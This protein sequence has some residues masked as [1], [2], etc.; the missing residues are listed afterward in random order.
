[1]Y[2]LP[3]LL[4]PASVESYAINLEQKLGFAKMLL[5]SGMLPVHYK[6]PEAV[7]TAILY[8]KEL[9]F[10][11]I[12][13]VN[14]I[15]VIQGRPTLEAQAMKALAIQKGGRVETIE[16]TNERCTLTCTRGDWKEEFTYTIADANLAGLSGKD[17]WR[18]MPK[19]MLYA[20]CVSTLVRNMFADVLC[21][22]YSTEE[23]RDEAPEVIP[24]DPHGTFDAIAKVIDKPEDDYQPVNWEGFKF[25]YHIP[26][27]KAG[28]DMEAVRDGLRKRGFQ[29][30]KEDWHWYG[31]VEVKKLNDYLRPLNAEQKEPPYEAAP[32]DVEF[33]ADGLEVQA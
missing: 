13:S 26:P 14:A 10:S 31:N 17:N 18:R 19:P 2:N 11:P 29:L 8:G 15:T 21:G 32:D 7:L 33:P 25:R 27:E 5:V 9:G 3:A 1:M 22:L 6:T 23:M 16:W 24:A 20:R 12:R 30:N 4:E 28:K